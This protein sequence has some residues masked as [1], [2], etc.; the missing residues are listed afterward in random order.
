MEVCAVAKRTEADD[1]PQQLPSVVVVNGV[2]IPT[3]CGGDGGCAAVHAHDLARAVGVPELKL[4]DVGFSNTAVCESKITFTDGE[5]GVLRYR[6]YPIEEL[7]EKS[8][9]LEV[10]FLLV[11]GELPTV[12]Q[13]DTWTNAI[14][15]HTY[16][17]ENLLRYL[18][19]FRYDAH[20]S[21]C[22]CCL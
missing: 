4:L 22:V 19:S 2:S 1:V 13:L 20:P 7:A 16:V 9:F 14:M 21:T 10:A 11:H 8:T 6:G 5:N 18:R 15:S 12:D 17:H 3:T